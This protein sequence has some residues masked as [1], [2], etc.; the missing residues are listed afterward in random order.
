LE[1]EMTNRMKLLAAV[2]AVALPAAMAGA[3]GTLHVPL[4]QPAAPPAHRTPRT[5]HATPTPA[6]AANTATED[7]QTTTSPADAPA[8]VNRHA[9]PGTQTDAATD[10]ATD[11]TNE[12]RTQART[13]PT[14]LPAPAAQ[15]Q[16][17]TPAGEAA[18]VAQARA[19]TPSAGQAAP[20]AQAQAEGATA[21]ATAGAVRAATAADLHSGVQVRDQSGGVV[22]TVESAD[23]TGAVV[24]TGSVR[25]RLPLT[26]FG[27]NGQNLVIS[28]SKAE[29]EAAA[30]HAQ[31]Q[32]SAG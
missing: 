31:A 10:A 32:P 8:T 15:A 2:A 25:A 19:Q 27:T 6:P 5:T 22:G 14:G 1:D 30:G 9:E 21:A 28:L 7:R 18:P 4:G 17:T 23:A 13:P 12:A 11:A 16:A 24:S 26:S 3:Q 20:A 29:L